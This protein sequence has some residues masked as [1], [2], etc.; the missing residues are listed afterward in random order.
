MS[1]GK[2]DNERLCSKSG[3]GGVSRSN[4]EGGRNELVVYRDACN[5]GG[6]WRGCDILSY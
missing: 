5:D 6:N 2:G 3:Q 4:E 1:V